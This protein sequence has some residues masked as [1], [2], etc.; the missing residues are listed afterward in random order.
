MVVVGK[1][2]LA[3]VTRRGHRVVP[4][5]V[6]EPNDEEREF[7]LRHVEGLRKTTARTPLGR[8]RPGSGTAALLGRALAAEDEEFAAVASELVDA[9]ADE[10][11]G[12]VAP[13]CVVAVLTHGDDVADTCSLLKLDAVTEGALLEEVDGAVRLEVFQNSL[14]SPGDLQKGISCPDPRDGSDVVVLDRGSSRAEYFLD[15]FGIDTSAKTLETER[16]FAEA[17]AELPA[18]ER[19][20]AVE[21]V[22]GGGTAEELVPL[23]RDRCPSFEARVPALG[24]GGGF[25]GAVRRDAVRSTEV[26]FETAG[27]TLRVSLD[28]LDRV[29]R[30][31]ED[32]DQYITAVRT[33]APMRRTDEG[34]ATEE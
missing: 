27:V 26:V 31:R 1:C 25:G 17:I 22:S 14:P 4:P 15:A 21:V 3:I 9:L 7:L 5:R 29:E 13:D 10:M 34:T 8:F 28:M 6:S 23:V 20:D 33:D 2:A 12:T 18:D 16:A 11:K 24:G 32:G 19:G 30:N